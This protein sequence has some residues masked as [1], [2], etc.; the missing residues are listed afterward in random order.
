MCFYDVCDLQSPTLGYLEVF[1]HFAIGVDHRCNALRFTP[2]NVGR[3]PQPLD[4]K[5]LREHNLYL[6]LHLSKLRKIIVPQKARTYA[7]KLRRVAFLDRKIRLAPGIHPPFQ[8][9][10]VKSRLD[11]HLCGRTTTIPGCA[12]THNHS[13]L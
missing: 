12:N 8:V 3:A 10:R 1:L 9:D 6:S 5:L 11:K 4:K 13:V 2:Y 7:D